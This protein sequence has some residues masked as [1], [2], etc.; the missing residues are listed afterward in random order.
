MQFPNV[1]G[2]T[3]LKTVAMRIFTLLFIMLILSRCGKDIPPPSYLHIDEFTL[4]QNID[5][6]YGQLTHAFMD[7]YV[8]INNQNYGVFPLPCT[9]PLNIEGPC[10]LR[11]MP[12][13]RTNGQS[14]AK[15]RYPFVEHHV[16]QVNFARLDTVH[17]QPRTQYYSTTQVWYE[18]FEDAAIQIQST[19]LS[20]TNLVKS[21]DPEILE[22]RNGN[23]FGKVLLN[24]TENIW[25]GI[26]N[27]NWSLSPSQQIYLEIDFYNTNS[28][29]TGFRSS[30]AGG[31]N[32]IG[33]VLIVPQKP[34][35]LRWRKMYIDFRQ[36]VTAVGIGNTFN[37]MLVSLLEEGATENVVAIDNIKLVY[38]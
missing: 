26:T 33:H 38:R 17:I 7:V 21:N 37:L 8:Y 22:A 23:F 24:S 25:D 31:V 30:G 28:I 32:S 13:V 20:L 15:T 2:F 11:M 10:E 9:I 34:E 27:A 6:N 29:Q 19:P 5:V 4:D 36:H 1:F 16:Q 14:G 12:A 3:Y 35:E 18:D